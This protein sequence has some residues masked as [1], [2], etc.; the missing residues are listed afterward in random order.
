MKIGEGE[1]PLFQKGPLPFPKPPSLPP[2]T[3]VRVNGVKGGAKGWSLAGVS[4]QKVKEKKSGPGN[5]SGPFLFL[6]KED[7][8]KNLSQTEKPPCRIR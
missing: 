4:R 5:N 8:K 3:F 6:R 7:P 2:K 1:G